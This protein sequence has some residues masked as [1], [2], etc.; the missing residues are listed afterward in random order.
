MYEV[1]PCHQVYPQVSS[2]SIPTGYLLTGIGR[3]IIPDM[4]KYEIRRLRVLKLME[5]DFEGVIAKFADRIERSPSY[6]GRMLYP[7]GKKAKKNIS[8]TLI[9]VIEDKCDLTPGWLDEIEKDAH[10]V[11]IERLWQ[12]LTNDNKTV[13]V[14]MIEA[15]AAQ[16]DSPQQ[17]GESTHN[18]PIVRS[19]FEEQEQS[20][21]A[22]KRNK[23]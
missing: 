11:A 6:V 9:E 12:N 8:D 14:K 16:R 18:D 5:E 21:A 10:L 23:K 19:E 7:A 22:H 20:D 17:L 1:V 2:M 3:A 15:M 4:D 13:A